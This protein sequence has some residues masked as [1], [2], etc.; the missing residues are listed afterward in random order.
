MNRRHILSL[1][2]LATS[3]L[4]LAPITA[5]AADDELAG[6]YKLISRSRVLVD[7]G[8]VVERVNRLYGHIVGISGT[9]ADD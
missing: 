2:L 9:D 4:A 5:S 6:T 1:S 8:K 7:S 3:G